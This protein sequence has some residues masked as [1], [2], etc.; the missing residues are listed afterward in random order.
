MKIGVITVHSA[1]DYA[2][3]LQTWA[4]QKLLRDYSLEPGILHYRTKDKSDIYDTLEAKKGLARKMQ[5]L[6]LYVFDRDSLALYQ[7]YQS[8]TKKN[9]HSS[10]NYKTYEELKAAR[11]KKDLWFICNGN[12]IKLG[13][14]EEE[15]P[16]DDNDMSLLKP[17]APVMLDPTMLLSKKDYEEIKVKKTVN[18]P[19][20]LLFTEEE[21]TSAVILANKI[22]DITGL[23]VIPNKPVRNLT[24][25]RKPYNTADAGEL[26]GF[27][28]GAAYV[29]TDSFHGTAFSILYG[30]P[31]VSMLPSDIESQTMDLLKELGLQSHILKDA[32]EFKDISMFNIENPK[33]LQ[34]QLQELRQASIKFLI[35]KL[36]LSDRYKK[37]KCPTNITKE[38]CYGCSA[39]KDI[40]PTN[41]IE[42]KADKEG[43][44]YPV[45]DKEKCTNCGLCSKACIR[46]HP[47][48][49]KYEEQY[50]KAYT[51]YHIDL[52]QRLNSS[53]GAVF[54]S[55]ARYAIE[56]RKGVVV[57]VRYD[58]NMKVISDIADN[59]EDAKAFSGS[60]YVKS[61]FQGIFP[62][63]KGLLK[64][65]R[66]VLYS[67]LPCECAALR[68][69]LRKDYENLLIS[70]LV[71]HAAPSPKV[72]RKYVEYLNKKYDSKV[73]NIIFRNKNNGWRIG[74]A[75]MI[76]TFENGK[77]E[78]HRSVEDPYFRAFLDEFTIRSSCTNCKYTYLNRAGD[79]TL[80]DC[81]GVSKAAPE[82][83]D[84]K[85]VS[86]LLVNNSKAM[87]VWDNVK[88]QFEIKENSAKE[89]FYKN[90]VK[91]SK[92]KRS[93]TAFFY[94]L[95]KEPIETLLARYSKKTST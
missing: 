29:I 32:A 52:N 12:S 8:F 76:I 38:K 89:I 64:E 51:T 33:R 93:R 17:E 49:V 11:N 14:S 85:G 71:C 18:E 19:Y 60:K 58:E 72:F 6:M 48:L 5:K 16:A 65:G 50:P 73:T 22:T 80:G 9:L 59:M 86:M 2:T 92:D 39:C 35:K 43:F 66:F 25:G 10:G 53:S 20:I 62:K 91:P 94:K 15:S 1:A 56:E 30:K 41:A 84:N 95:N 87:E 83:F 45:T 79:I 55:L 36:E 23:P 13:P 34:K 61:D 78:T 54:P 44:L 63:V 40:C 74:D 26:L 27:I 47:N 46:K 69:Y 67:G 82:L 90:H 42:M 81:W 7:K 70:E 77:T 28:E 88:N 24:K 4:M 37:L 57:G 21:N 31:F 75:N 3:I 68:S